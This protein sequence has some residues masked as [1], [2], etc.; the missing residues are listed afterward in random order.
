M[1]RALD[2]DKEQTARDAVIL[3]FRNRNLVDRILDYPGDRIYITC[4]TAHLP[5]S[6][7]C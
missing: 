3:D 6:S 2:T 1:A 4:G 7:S 5:G